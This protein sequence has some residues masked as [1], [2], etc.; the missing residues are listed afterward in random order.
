MLQVTEEEIK[1]CSSNLLI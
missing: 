1:K